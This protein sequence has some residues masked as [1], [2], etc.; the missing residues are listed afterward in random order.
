MNRR[1]FLGRCIAAAGTQALSKRG[2]SLQGQRAAP[3]TPATAANQISAVQFPD[4]FLWGMATASYQV[5][6]AWNE[7]GKGESIWDTAGKIKN[8]GDFA[9]PSK[10]L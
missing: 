4:D 2:F 3:G 10:T 1:Q 8:N 7:D 6:G 9:S 5:E